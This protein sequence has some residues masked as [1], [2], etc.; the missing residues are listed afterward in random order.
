MTIADATHTVEVA[1][2]MLLAADTGE[3]QKP[4]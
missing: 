4:G 2:A 3:T 1:E